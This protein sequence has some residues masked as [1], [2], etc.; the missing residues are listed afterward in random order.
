MAH[1]F[2]WTATWDVDFDEDHPACLGGQEGG[3]LGGCR[4]ALTSR[5]QA[6]F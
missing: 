6:S 1:R 4:R 5:I 2:G 3:F